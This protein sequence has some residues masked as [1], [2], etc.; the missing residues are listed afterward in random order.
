M[1]IKIKPPVIMYGIYNT[2]AHKFQFGIKEPSKTKAMKKLFETIGKDAYRW[3]FEA[4]K[5]PV[6]KVVSS[7]SNSKISNTQT[8]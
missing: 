8:I 3:R 4:K 2:M 7:E 5:L 6:E 1:E